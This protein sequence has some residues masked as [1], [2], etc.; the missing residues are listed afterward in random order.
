M[1]VLDGTRDIV[2]FVPVG[3][4]DRVGELL[5]FFENE[6]VELTEIEFVGLVDIVE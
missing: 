1:V 4:G 3:C 2:A 5:A 6:L